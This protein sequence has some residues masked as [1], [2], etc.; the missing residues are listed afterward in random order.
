M[1]LNKIL[2]NNQGIETN[3]HRISHATLSNNNLDCI[4]ES[5]VSKDYREL[6][7]SA[8]NSFFSFEI[9]SASGK[10]KSWSSYND[11]NDNSVFLFT[12]DKNADIIFENGA[13]VFSGEKTI[14]ISYD[15]APAEIKNFC[16]AFSSNSDNNDYSIY[17][18]GYLLSYNI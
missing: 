2:I 17:I 15:N 14:Y 9:M 1:A 18:N 5:Y 7:R 3:Y 10:G 8:D 12:D 4:L 13:Y 6:E 11:L 16:K